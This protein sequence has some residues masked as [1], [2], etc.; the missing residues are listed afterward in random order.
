MIVPVFYFLSKNIHL[1]SHSLHRAQK[2]WKARVNCI[3][4]VNTQYHNN[5]N[6]TVCTHCWWVVFRKLQKGHKVLNSKTQDPYLQIVY[7]ELREWCNSQIPNLFKK[8][9]LSQHSLT[10]PEY[11]ATLV[12]GQVTWLTKRNILGVTGWG[13]QNLEVM[14]RHPLVETLREIYILCN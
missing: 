5:M 11:M 6:V 2:T 14:Q 4:S 10:V 1:Q 3:A 8:L 12:Y 13:T 7:F 9:K